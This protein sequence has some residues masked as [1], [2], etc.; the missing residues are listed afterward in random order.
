[1][2]WVKFWLD[3]LCDIGIFFIAF[4]HERYLVFLRRLKCDGPR[5]GEL[6]LLTWLAL[7][8]A[9]KGKWGAKALRKIRAARAPCSASARGHG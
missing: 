2:E 8:L 3:I 9:K 5:V 1:V 6:F 4:V 7:I